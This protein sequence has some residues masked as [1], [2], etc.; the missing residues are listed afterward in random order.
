MVIEV[1]LAESTPAAKV[2]LQALGFEVKND[3]ANGRKLI[4]S[5][6]VDKLD[7]LVRLPFVQFI[8]F[9]RR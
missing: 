5:L 2:Q 8:S 4:G 6:P 9:E 7:N 3:H 1:F